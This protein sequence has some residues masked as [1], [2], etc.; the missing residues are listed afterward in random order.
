VEHGERGCALLGEF[1]ERGI[2]S[3]TLAMLAE[4]YYALDRLDDA[5]SEAGRAAEL[6]AR[7]DART[8]MHWRQ[9][10]AKVLGRRG[11]HA[12]GER[13]A[14]EAV[15]LGEQTDLLSYQADAYADLAETLLLAGRAREAEEALQEALARYERKGNLVMAER[16][17]KKLA[18]LRPETAPSEQI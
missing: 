4:A 12:E 14:R 16:A 8:Q 17:R 9:V 3:T 11:E 5:D 18:D 10:R 15:A 7:D 2:L 13:L 1:G 6:G